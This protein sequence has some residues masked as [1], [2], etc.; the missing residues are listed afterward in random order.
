MGLR[1]GRFSCPRTVHARCGASWHADAAV[2]SEML[3]RDVHVFGRHSDHLTDPV[4][5]SVK[6]GTIAAI[7]PGLA[8]GSG[9]R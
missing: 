3:F 8:A 5:V 2:Q 6:N 4:N 1:G 9:H 7:G